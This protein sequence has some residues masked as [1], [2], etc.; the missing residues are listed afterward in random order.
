MKKIISML[1][2]AVMLVIP[3][4]VLANADEE[5]PVEST[6]AK[7]E[8]TIE[9]APTP[10]F[11]NDNMLIIKFDKRY[12]SACSNKQDITIEITTKTVDSTDD[13]NGDG[14]DGGDESDDDYDE[15]AT[16]STVTFSGDD[17]IFV[18]EDDDDY[19]SPFIAAYILHAG[20]I[21][22]YNFY[23]AVISENTVFDAQGKGNKVITLTSMT[24][25]FMWVDSDCGYH[26]ND[27]L[28][29][30]TDIFFYLD[31][32]IPADFYLDGELV[33]EDSVYYIM[34]NAERG[35]HTVSAKKLGI[36][37]DEITFN[38]NKIDKGA[39]ILGLFAE[40]GMYF[41]T[42]LYAFPL[43]PLLGLIIPPL[44]IAGLAS[45]F[46]AIGA[47]FMAIIQS[48]TVLFI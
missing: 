41:L 21:D 35:T 22:Y 18:K 6:E 45:P 43:A 48:V 27:T 46:V 26:F 16:Y 33:A 11:D 7:D 39:T 20:D 34:K 19:F 10:E 3:L 42:S 24:Q 12:V 25:C 32:R 31:S 28:M 23:R 38:A 30:K 5:N 14:D 29:E 2:A 9:F 44:G 37:V 1:L 13:E 8:T 17:L 4:S 47:F 40:S 15:N 36:V